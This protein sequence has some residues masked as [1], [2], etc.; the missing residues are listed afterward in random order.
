MLCFH[1]L[2]TLIA[3]KQYAM[4]NFLFFFF[5]REINIKYF[6]YLELKQHNIFKVNVSLLSCAAYSLVAALL[7][8]APYW[9]RGSWHMS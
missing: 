8:P 4:T 2:K 5:L 7:L 6:Y 3:R 9:P 1:I